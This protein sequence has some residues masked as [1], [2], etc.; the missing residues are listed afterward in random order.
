MGICLLIIL[1]G[2]TTMNLHIDTFVENKETVLKLSGE[3][4][5]HTAPKLKTTLLELLSEENNNVVVDLEEV[6]YMDS[7]GLGVFISALKQSKDQNSSFKLINLQEN[8]Y[9][10]FNITGLDE[11]I[12]IVNNVRGGE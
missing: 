8:V 11:V 4:D 9:R 10:L 1:L 6:S 2:G 5:A 3:I 7:T 12:H